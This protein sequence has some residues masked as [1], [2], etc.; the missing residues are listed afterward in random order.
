[1]DRNH[2][3]ELQY[4]G[5]G[6]RGW[7]KQAGLPTVEGCLE[8]ALARI[9][10]VCPELR[11]AGRTDSG[12]HARRQVVSLLLPGDVDL[13]LLR[14]SLNALTP[15][16][17]AVTRL[18]PAP[19]DFNARR[20]ARSRTYRYFI[21]DKD[22]ASPFWVRYS[23]PIWGDLDPDALMAT[24]AVVVGHHDFS[25]FTPTETEHVFFGRKVFRCTWERVGGEG[26]PISAA[27]SCRDGMMF[28]EIEADSFLRHMVRVLVGTMVE[29]A[30]G[31]RSHED[32]ALLLGG[33]SRDTA[34]RTA[35]AHGLFL[36]D[37][38]YGAVD[39]IR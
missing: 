11:V 25:A 1:M 21:S 33:A 34:G 23:W 24:A 26:W 20:D 17:I 8:T 28:L 14:R 3:M 38:D 32:L 31:R 12:V 16:G 5:T 6:L 35:P 19:P 29:V 22:A 2:R 27:G 30:T 13:G 39:S 10:G 4:D 37:V 15:A 9:L 18:D 36:W 7:A